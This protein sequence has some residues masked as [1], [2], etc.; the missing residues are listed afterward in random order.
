MELSQQYMPEHFPWLIFAVGET[1]ILLAIG[2]FFRRYREGEAV[3]SRS[4]QKVG[5]R[6][7]VNIGD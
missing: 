2:L 6:I 7:S 1:V 4:T 5:N 3:N